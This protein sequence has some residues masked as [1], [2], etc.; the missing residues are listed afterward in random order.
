MRCAR[1][2]GADRRIQANRAACVHMHVHASRLGST[3][4]AARDGRASRMQYAGGAGARG[5]AYRHLLRFFNAHVQMGTR[6]KAPQVRRLN[7][8]Q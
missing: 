4:R 2:R 8:Q 1:G 6:G 5:A 3:L 7:R